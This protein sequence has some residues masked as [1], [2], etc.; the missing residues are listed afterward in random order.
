MGNPF[1]V[2]FRRFAGGKGFSRRK[3]AE[4]KRLCEKNSLLKRISRKSSGGVKFHP[5]GKRVF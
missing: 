4:E 3:G 2:L 1:E 5:E